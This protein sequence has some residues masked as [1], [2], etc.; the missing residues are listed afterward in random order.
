MSNLDGKI[1]LIITDQVC[2]CEVRLCVCLSS[3]HSSN[4]YSIFRTEVKVLVFG[5]GSL[6]LNM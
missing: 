6:A 4:L 5:F 2:S 1:R 3:P